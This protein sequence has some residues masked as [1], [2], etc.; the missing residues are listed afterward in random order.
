WGHDFRPEY[1]ELRAL[2]R[3]FPSIPLAAFTATATA[4]VQEDIISQL[5]LREPAHFRGTFNRPNL[6][7]EV[8][9]K[10]DALAVLMRYLKARPGDSGI[11]YCLSRAGTEELAT[12]LQGEGIKAVSYHAGLDRRQ[13]EQRQ[14]DFVKDRAQVIVATIAFGMGIDK[15]DVRYVIHYDLPRTLE[16][17]Y[18]ESGRAGRDGEA[19]DCI[20][21]YSPADI[22]RARW[23]ADQKEDPHERAIAH[24]QLK[25][26][27]A[28][29]ETTE[30]RRTTLLAHFDERIEPPSGRCCDNCAAP[31]PLQDVTVPAQ[32]FLS[33]VKRTGERFGR[34]Y[35]IDV[36]RGSRSARVREQG[37]ESL[38]TYGIGR[39]RSKE[40]WQE[41]AA[42]LLREDYLVP[43]DEFGGLKV[44]ERGSQVLFKGL[45]VVAPVRQ[46]P[47]AQIRE[48]ERRDRSDLFEQL[49]LLRKRLAE[50]A[51]VP[52]YVIFQ[53]P[54]LWEMVQRRPKTLSE[55]S[56]IPGV[57]EKRLHDY[58]SAFLSV[59]AA[60]A[61]S[62][63][64][65]DPAR[66]GGRT[67]EQRSLNTSA[68]VSLQ[69]FRSGLGAEDIARE[70]G[71]AVTTIENHL[72]TAL[73]N[74]E[75]LDINRLV[76]EERRP[77]IEAVLRRMPGGGLSPVKEQLGDGYS[78]GEIRLTQAWME[79]QLPE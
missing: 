53:D 30:C 35:V 9:P 73:L 67:A 55:L 75:E 36:L 39:N 41:L 5:E 56:R 28:W 63:D 60:A 46:R 69:L 42:M 26:M 47:R 77:A 62:S 68:M 58:G 27:T 59:L 6:Y 11:I 76:P 38:P 49:R 32:M 79:R 7:Y 78:Y 61:E 50:E 4:R 19:S 66:A 52:A 22:S 72:A 14:E 34:S 18:Q 57:G 25:H 40:D 64:Q 10:Q 16:N 2:R 71:L 44:T 43:R 51:G 37:H 17:Y 45:K 20:L 48:P 33:C 24:E 1:R 13:R 23:F 74:G 12:V 70:R 54:A 8:R 21:F 3:S 31:T 15:P 65:P 29:A